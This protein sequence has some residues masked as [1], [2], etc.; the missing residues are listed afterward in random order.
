M[1]LLCNE[2]CY[3][4]TDII[5]QNWWKFENSRWQ[6]PSTEIFFKGSLQTDQILRFLTTFLSACKSQDGW[7]GQKLDAFRGQ[8]AHS[9]NSL[10]TLVLMSSMCLETKDY[11]D[12]YKR[13]EIK[14]GG[15]PKLGKVR[16]YLST[17]HTFETTL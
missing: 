6:V 17:K 1:L 10:H 12:I 13:A 3:Y 2:N 15:Y 8:S 11:Y 4:E 14:G 9:K 7:L 16:S 5:A